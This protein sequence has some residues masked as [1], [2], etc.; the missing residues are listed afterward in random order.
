[1]RIH[2]DRPDEN[3]WSVSPNDSSRA[4]PLGVDPPKTGGVTG[5]DYYDDEAYGN[6]G[7]G[8]LRG[9]LE[10][11]DEF[12]TVPEGTAWHRGLD[13]GLLLVRSVL[14]VVFV[15]H[16]ARKLFGAFG[17]AGLDGTA[18]VLAA[19]GFRRTEVLAAVT[20]VTE[21]GAGILLV[22]GLFTP[23]A[24]AGVLGVM[25]GAVLLR[26]GDGFF[27]D[28]GGAEYP[29]LVG[30]VALGLLFTGPGRASVDNGS[31]WFRRPVLSGT[32][33]LLLAAAVVTGVLL[34]LR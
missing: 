27:L 26:A 34:G 29:L 23:L 9:D 7:A 3:G 10:F 32:T 1:M 6:T 5:L 28:Q 13:L 16:G 22:L 15:A 21:F 14:G 33:G 12:P 11:H 30:A 20:G 18:E 24:A 4:D 8:A 31:V 25:T 2:D 19:A 17:G